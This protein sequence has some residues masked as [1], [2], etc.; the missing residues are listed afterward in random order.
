MKSI[1]GLT[2]F[3]FMG[4]SAFGQEPTNKEI[5]P[6]TFKSQAE[7]DAW[8]TANPSE[9]ARLKSEAEQ[10]SATYLGSLLRIEADPQPVKTSKQDETAKEKVGEPTKKG[11]A[12]AG[13]PTPPDLEG[14][15]VMEDTGD[16]EA[17]Q[18]RYEEAKK[19]WYEQ[20]DK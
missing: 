16:A 3:I 18:K 10:I 6:L 8:I 17:D 9:Y 2:F 5:Q 7:L 13:K 1:V 15:P 4:S 12:P 11:K 19:V 14:F 20:N